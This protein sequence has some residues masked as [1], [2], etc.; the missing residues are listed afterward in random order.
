MTPVS[1]YWT[2]ELREQL[3]AI[4]PCLEIC[5]VIGL[6]LDHVSYHVLGLFYYFRGHYL[7]A[8][9]YFDKAIE[10]KSDYAIAYL[11]KGI[12]LTKLESKRY[13]ESLIAYN[14]AIEID[15]NFAEAYFYRA[16]SYLLMGN[17]DAASTDLKSAI[18]L[19]PNIK[20]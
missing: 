18:E 12:T 11:Y 2:P 20:I 6:N 5:E 7:T 14:K 16:C 10:I 15:P 1:K 19:D 4:G 8:I 17:K 9:E 3:E 13:E